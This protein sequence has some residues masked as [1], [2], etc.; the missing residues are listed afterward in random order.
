MSLKY[1]II[2]AY[3]KNVLNGQIF[4]PRFK[5]FSAYVKGFTWIILI[6][7]ISTRP[8]RKYIVSFPYAIIAFS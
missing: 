1:V 2:F 8:T 7:S 6:D 4:T 3:S 5:K